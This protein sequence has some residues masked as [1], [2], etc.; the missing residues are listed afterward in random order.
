MAAPATL[1]GKIFLI[2]YGL[3]GCATTILFFSLFLEHTITLIT[4]LT[5]WCRKQRRLKTHLNTEPGDGQENWKPSVYYVTLILAVVAFVVSCGASG[6]YSAM[7]DWPYLESMY[8]CFVAFSTMGFGDMV[9]VQRACYE[10][11]WVYQI[12]NSLMI[13]LGVSCT[14]SLFNVTSV[15]IRQMLNWILAKLFGLRGCSAESERGAE[16][17]F[18]RCSVA[19]LNITKTANQ[20]T[21]HG[22]P[23]GTSLSSENVCTRCT[24]AGEDTVCER[25]TRGKVN[26]RSPFGC[27]SITEDT[28]AVS[29]H[30]LH[31]ININLEEHYKLNETT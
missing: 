14:Y 23:S 19:G 17:Q 26:G 8:F 3:I 12:A 20:Q 4:V 15:I 27:G 7:E 28:T 13:I 18:C 31:E 6:L 9:S 29:N 2:F 1:N 21:H 11:R 30:H 10:A 24:S 22:Q 5:R 25:K 16:D